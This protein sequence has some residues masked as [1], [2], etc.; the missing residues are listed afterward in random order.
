MGLLIPRV[1]HD[2]RCVG[3]DENS[4]LSGRSWGVSVVA[5]DPQAARRSLGIWLRKLGR[6]RRLPWH[7]VCCVLQ[8]AM[9]FS[10]PPPVPESL[11]HGASSW[12]ALLASTA[13]GSDGFDHVRVHVRS[14]DGHQRPSH[15]RRRLVAQSY[16][17]GD[18]D[19]EGRPVE[20]ARPLS[21]AQRE[22]TEEEL[23]HGLMLDLVAVDTPYVFGTSIIAWVEAGDADLEFDGLMSRPQALALFGRGTAGPSHHDV[24]LRPAPV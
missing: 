17:A 21:S 4:R 7:G 14:T 12:L 23:A 24:L 5:H 18:L 8:A 13:L 6:V 20:G 1:I 15:E 3:V 22:V 2:R 9:K 19:A 11:K 10:L 16:A